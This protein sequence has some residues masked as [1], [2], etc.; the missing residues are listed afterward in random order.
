M[1]YYA[2]IQKKKWIYMDWHGKIS[3]A[4]WLE[5]KETYQCNMNDSSPLSFVIRHVDI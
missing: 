3:K 1:E 4:D 5:K 2:L